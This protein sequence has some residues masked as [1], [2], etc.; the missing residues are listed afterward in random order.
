[1][2]KILTMLSCTMLLGSMLL[3]NSVFTHKEMTKIIKNT[4]RPEADI[5]LDAMRK[6]LKVLSFF[7]AVKAGDKVLDIDAGSGYY[8][9]ILSALVGNQGMV[10]AQEPNN[11]HGKKAT[12]ILE[13]T[14]KKYNIKNI[15]IISENLSD[16]KFGVN[17]FNYINASLTL[18]DLINFNSKTKAIATLK[19]VHR[20]LKKGGVL[21]IVDHVGLDG[22]D[23]SKLHRASVKTM[24]ADVTKA[25]FN[26]VASSN[27]L[28]NP[29]D[30]H[31]VI[32]FDPSIRRHTDRMVLKFT[33]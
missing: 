17:N 22:V 27:I 16:L 3:A 9:V 1:M 28:A 7:N 30:N 5:K 25:G 33:K 23:N 10:Y 14:I 12:K 13:A 6:P 24:K 18:H 20:M 4:K 8:T 32:V 29:K 31:K 19:N 21:G 11:A 2:K 26:F 15:K